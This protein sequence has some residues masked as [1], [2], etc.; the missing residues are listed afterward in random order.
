MINQ[1][2][3]V[4]DFGGQYSHL[5]ARRVRECGV[6][7]EVKP[8]TTAVETLTQM[9]PAGIILTGGPNSV[10]EGKSP[11]C[12]GALF[13]MGVPILGICYGAQLMAHLN[14]GHVEKAPR[15][16]YGGV[17][18]TVTDPKSP[19]YDEVE[20]VFT[21][22]MSHTDFISA[23]PDGFKITAKTDTCPCAAMENAEKRL[24]AVQFHPEVVHTECGQKI[25]S[26]F[27]NNICG[28]QNDWHMSEYVKDTIAQLKAK[29][30]DKKVIC[31]LSGGVDSTVASVLVHQA[32]GDNLTCIFIDHGMLRKDEGDM[33]EEMCRSKFGMNLIRVNAQEQFLSKLEGVKDPETKR[34]IIGEEFI[35]AFEAESKKIGAVSFLVQG[36]I[37]PDIIESGLGDSAVIKSHH[38]VGGLPDVV[39]FEEII[40]PSACSLKTKFERRA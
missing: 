4:L 39:D 14:G 9:K 25:L 36:T 24:F 7:C 28:C 12:S 10:Y 11:L 19:L 29:I 31:G 30:G 38:N 40:E 6:Y 5:I 16:E 34:K 20:P 22:W 15:G 27:L 13:D 37:Y 1:L 8:Y 2:V 33:V 32:V 35:R 26:N 23:V 17:V 21:C 18:L 3:V